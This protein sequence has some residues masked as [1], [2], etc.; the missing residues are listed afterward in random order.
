MANAPKTNAVDMVTP[1][2]SA[3]LV[4]VSKQCY[5]SE[6]MVISYHVEIWREDSIRED[7]IEHQW[8]E[9]CGF[10]IDLSG[11]EPKLSMASHWRLLELATGMHPSFLEMAWAVIDKLWGL[12][13][14]LKSRFMLA[15][16]CSS[17]LTLERMP[18]KSTL[19]PQFSRTRVT[20][21]SLWRICP[22]K[23]FASA[24]ALLSLSKTWRHWE[25]AFRRCNCSKYRTCRTTL[26][27]RRSFCDAC[28]HASI[29]SLP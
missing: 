16:S 23:S 1:T 8:F 6:K 19:R 28:A 7:S 20:Q 13:A 22:V 17:T 18:S 9:W 10:L 24:A 5:A 2:W 25:R 12:S 15:N 21:P 14:L 27:G 3:G 26:S 29:E 4:S 11:L